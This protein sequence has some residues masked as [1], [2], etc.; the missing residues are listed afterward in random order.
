VEFVANLRTR[1]RE[2]NSP[3]QFPTPF[4]KKSDAFRVDGDFL[5]F[6]AGNDAW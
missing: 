3:D 5:Q 4:A 1:D 2:K 6:D